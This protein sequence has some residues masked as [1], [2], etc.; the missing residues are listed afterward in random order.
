METKHRE[1]TD[2]QATDGLKA[3]E[4]EVDGGIKKSN[5]GDSGET[6]NTGEFQN[7]TPRDDI[8]IDG[9][10]K[11]AFD[12]A[13]DPEKTKITNIGLLGRYSSGKSSLVDSYL[14][15]REEEIRDKEIKSK[16]INYVKISFAHFKY[17]EKSTEN[18]KGSDDKKN[19]DNITNSNV[20]EKKIV[21][22]L[23]N[24][25][26]YKKINQTSFYVKR[27]ITYIES[28]AF[29]FLSILSFI[30][31]VI[32]S[33]NFINFFKIPLISG[34]VT[35]ILT[36]SVLV[37]LISKVYVLIKSGY[38][39]KFSKLELDVNKNDENVKSYFDVYLTEIIYVIEN[40]GLNLIIFEDIDRFEITSIFERLHEVNGIV[41]R[42][43]K[44]DSNK[45]KCVKFL[46]VLEDIFNSD[47]DK[48]KFFD[49][50]IPTPNIVNKSNSYNIFYK[51]FEASNLK[52]PDYNFL[53]EVSKYF[54]D[55]R[56]IKGIYNEFLIYYDMVVKEIY[57]GD[58]KNVDVNKIFAIV[59]YKHILPKDF[60]LLQRNEGVLHYLLFEAKNTKII[61]EIL[62]TENEIEINIENKKGIIDY[63]KFLILMDD[64][65]I[66]NELA[67][68][69]NINPY[70]LRCD[71]KKIGIIDYISKTTD[72]ED[73]KNYNDNYSIY[74][75]HGVLFR[76]LKNEDL[77]LL[78]IAICRNMLRDFYNLYN[79]SSYTKLNT[80]LKYILIDDES[81]DEQ[82][83]VK[84][85]VYNL[86][87]LY[88]K[89]G[90]DNSKYKDLFITLVTKG[91]LDKEILVYTRIYNEK[92]SDEEKNK[93]IRKT[94][95]YI[96]KIKSSEQSYDIQYYLNNFEEELYYEI[97]LNELDLE[98]W[99]DNLNILN[100]GLFDYLIEY[101]IENAKTYT[102]NDNKEI[103]KA[104]M[105]NL[106]SSVIKYSHR[107]QKKDEESKKY[108]KNEVDKYFEFKNEVRFAFCFKYFC[109]CL[110]SSQNSDYGMFYNEILKY[111]KFNNLS[112]INKRYFKDDEKKYKQNFLHE[113]INRKIFYINKENLD[114][115]FN[116]YDYEYVVNAYYNKSYKNKKIYEE[117]VHR[118]IYEYISLESYGNYCLD[119]NYL[120]NMISFLSINFCPYEVVRLFLYNIKLIEGKTYDYYLKHISLQFLKNF[121]EE[122]VRFIYESCKFENLP[123]DDHIYFHK[124]KDYY[125]VEFSNVK[126][127]THT[128]KNEI[129]NVDIL[130]IP[131]NYFLM[132]CLFRLH[133]KDDG[134]CEVK[135]I[136]DIE[137]KTFNDGQSYRDNE[138][139]K[140]IFCEIIPALNSISCSAFL[141][142]AFEKYNKSQNDNKEY[143]EYINF[144][145][146]KIKNNYEYIDIPRIRR[147]FTF[148]LF[149]FEKCNELVIFQLFL[150]SMNFLDVKIDYEIYEYLL[151]YSPPNEFLCEDKY[152]DIIIDS[153][154]TKYESG[155]SEFYNLITK[156]SYMYLGYIIEYITQELKFW[157]FPRGKE[158]FIFSFDKYG[159]VIPISGT[160]D[161]YN[162][163][164]EKNVRKGLAERI[165]FIVNY[166]MDFSDI[167]NVKEYF[168]IDLDEFREYDFDRVNYVVILY[169][170]RHLLDEMIEIEIDLI[171]EGKLVKA[172]NFED[173]IPV[174]YKDKIIPFLEF[175]I[176]SN[177]INND[178]YEEMLFSIAWNKEKIFEILSEKAEVKLGKNDI[179]ILRKLCSRKLLHKKL[180]F[181]GK[182]AIV[183]KSSNLY[184]MIKK[185]A[186][187]K[188]K[189]GALNEDK[190]KIL[191]KLGFREE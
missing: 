80:L 110:T 117:A 13:L 82:L 150:E 99:Y 188:S 75:E 81:S 137:G 132:L 54:T 155:E 174:Y 113:I 146:E 147:Y 28:I 167:L 92:I 125:N 115:I 16:G 42:K 109:R 119:N 65:Y 32:I 161:I 170:Y 96:Q 72:M 22:Q 21:N 134:K 178:K 169:K 51:L 88:N 153:I 187:D 138:K 141:K 56:V 66:L 34:I 123:M 95:E 41:N 45:N 149:K 186:N 105:L 104:F 89:D 112:Y 23:I 44:K 135:S 36:F 162:R 190:L 64:V 47:E 7:F 121:F 151:G 91:Y 52:K 165:T 1:E 173:Y 136:F 70:Y 139:N 130:E 127:I 2:K 103:N 43:L 175:I 176:T 101:A 46:Y 25:V 128:Y 31:L 12:Y 94:R 40:S 15:Q 179:T 122:Y 3:K 152:R 38:K 78:Y 97:I 189:V 83:V 158:T 191:T 86:L 63:F 183:Y 19:I 67:S 58:E 48:H 27:K 160:E 108:K 77:E 37:F 69:L 180:E 114:F 18:G 172:L 90:I 156:Y 24:L 87:N 79:D 74:T 26:D 107:L 120:N 143:R 185:I 55:V 61:E 84:N 11:E 6:V 60:D 159:K 171:K 98:D 29:S 124:Y 145:I 73:I 71:F 4:I 118:H 181:V 49:F 9:K 8:K 168:F 142:G 53:K 62:G 140:L 68:S 177:E 57:N 5:G 106:F 182:E 116:E 33:K 50:I 131:L 93:K 166:F 164:R 39:F 126:R 184:G 59:V 85:F 35:I 163:N 148:K 111:V 17:N 100:F 10:L 14:K 30:C 157:G 20:L 102:P 129:F 133:D 76:I 154:N 144:I